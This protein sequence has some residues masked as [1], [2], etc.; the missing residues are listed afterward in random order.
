M[1]THAAR[2]W[3]FAPAN[4]QRRATK[5]LELDA[6]AVILD[7]EDA[8]AIAEKSATRAV[9]R[10]LLARP[11]TGAALVRVNAWN[12]EF[13]HGDI[14]AVVGPDLDG[15]VL[16]KVESASCLIAIDWLIANLERQRGLAHGSVDLV[17]IIETARG[18][19]GAR[20]IAA[21]GTRVRRLAFGAGD[22]TLDLGIT[23]SAHEN[24]LVH[25]R[26]ELVLASRCARLEP[27]VDTVFIDIRDHAG[28]RASATLARDLG[29]Q[30]KLC[31]HPD[32][33]GITNE[34][35][36]PSTAEVERCQAIVDAFEQAEQ[37][38]LASIQVDGY[39]VDYPIY[40]KA[41]RTLAS[42]RS[43][44]STDKRSASR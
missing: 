38:G 34:V 13:C 11:R 44:L 42:V 33:V 36:S 31:I 40:E 15:I 35:F 8:V 30:G 29:F 21:A 32:Q 24:E 10:D 43:S 17:P 12:T 14:D 27:P 20:E 25:A 18:L 9:V 5:A 28:F 16:P 1:T 2:S 6:D 39:F 22:F 3:L 7:L 41:V 19:A 23:W 26:S 4:H 37:A